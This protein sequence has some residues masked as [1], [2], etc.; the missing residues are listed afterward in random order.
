MITTLGLLLTT[1][2]S[3]G[4]VKNICLWIS[5]QILERV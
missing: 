3:L 5:F 4:N 1:F 2:V